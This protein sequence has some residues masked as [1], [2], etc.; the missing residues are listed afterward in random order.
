[1]ATVS[2]ESTKTRLQ[3]LNP[4]VQPEKSRAKLG[5]SRF[6]QESP[7]PNR[8]LGGGE[9]MSF[10][11]S[12]TTSSSTGINRA[13]QRQPDQLGKTIRTSKRPETATEID[14]PSTTPPPPHPKKKT[15][16]RRRL[17][18]IGTVSLMDRWRSAVEGKRSKK[19][20]GKT[21]RCNS[22]ESGR[23][24]LEIAIQRGNGSRVLVGRCRFWV[25]NAAAKAADGTRRMKLNQAA[26]AAAASGNQR[27]AVAEVCDNWKW[28][29]NGATTPHC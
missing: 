24:N 6:L 1:M 22:I 20:L 29:V 5:K 18:S 15:P 27:G 16:S 9:S 3:S 13:R 10:G 7:L 17:V 26:A 25:G 23:G 2:A 14:A 11:A 12:R 28:F 19:K 8:R 21:I 4:K